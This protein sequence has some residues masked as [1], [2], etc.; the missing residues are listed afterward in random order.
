MNRALIFVINVID[1]YEDDPIIGQRLYREIRKVELKKG[2]GKSV[3]PIPSSCY[4]WETVATNLDEFEDVSVS[5]SFFL[6]FDFEF[7]R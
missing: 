5:L 7:C 4:H 6:L 3:Q 1:R 2:K